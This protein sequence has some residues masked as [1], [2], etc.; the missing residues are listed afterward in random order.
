MSTP[1]PTTHGQFVIDRH[2]VATPTRTFAAWAD[3]ALRAQWFI[4]PENWKALER[5]FDF[6]V[7]GEEILRGAFGDRETLFT[8]RYHLVEPEARV[9]YVYDMHVAG[10]HHSVSLATIEF[11]AEGAGTHLHFTEQVAFVDGTPGDEGTAS[12]RRGTDEHLERLGA[13][14]EAGR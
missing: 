9:V 11:I 1:T 3:P 6:R 14:L 13:V 2:Y 12:R 4:G 8:A 7:G 5:R 10:R